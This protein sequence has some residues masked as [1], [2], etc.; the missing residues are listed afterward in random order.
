MTNATCRACVAAEGRQ[1]GA[2]VQMLLLLP[3]TLKRQGRAGP[4]RAWAEAGRRHGAGLGNKHALVQRSVLPVTVQLVHVL[5]EGCSKPLG[6]VTSPTLILPQTWR[7]A[8]VKAQLGSNKLEL[9]VM[10]YAASPGPCSAT[11]GKRVVRIILPTAISQ[12]LGGG[13]ADAAEGHH[14]AARQL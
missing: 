13:R 10:V 8:A 11:S 2:C 1:H 14:R 9:L 3:C 7:L 6:A 12:V 4:V 5:A